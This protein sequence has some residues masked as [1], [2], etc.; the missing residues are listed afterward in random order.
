[1]IRS[2]SAGWVECKT[3]GELEKLAQKSPHRSQLDINNKW[4]S[5]YQLVNVAIFSNILNKEKLD[6]QKLKCKI[7]GLTHSFMVPFCVKGHV[8]LP[9]SG[10]ADN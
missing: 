6:M 1:M 5:P 7:F 4:Q 10:L 8:M 2:H 9:M 3:E